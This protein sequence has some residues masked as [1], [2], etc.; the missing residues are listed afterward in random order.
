MPKAIDGR[1]R[2]S[3]DVVVAVVRDG[4]SGCCE[5][6][7]TPGV[8]KLTNGKEGCDDLRKHVRG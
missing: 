3:D 4:S 5:M 1:T 8:A 2:T 6:Y 7:F